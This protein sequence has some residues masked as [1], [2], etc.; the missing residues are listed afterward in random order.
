[1]LPKHRHPI[2]FRRAHPLCT[3]AAAALMAGPVMA[4]DV[5]VDVKA[6]LQ[7]PA[8]QA[9]IGACLSEKARFCPDIMPGGGRVVR[10]LAV[11]VDRLTPRCRTAMMEA[12]DALV[13]AGIVEFR[14]PPR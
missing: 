13:S 1:M 7:T 4:Q 9:A 3:F 14:A 5:N 12:Q 10:C 6:A 11:N 8:V 2:S